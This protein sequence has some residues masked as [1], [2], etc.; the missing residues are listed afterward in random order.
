M[1]AQQ[2][3]ILLALGV[4]FWSGN[5][6]L[7]R[8]ISTQIEPIELAFFRWF[9]VLLFISPTLFFLNIKKLLKVFKNNFLIMS[10]LALL[11]I[12]L[13]NTIVY[14]AVQTTTA[15]NALL[16]NSTTPIIILIFAHYILKNHISTKQIFGILL[17]TLGVC[18]LILKGQVQ[19]I[20]LLEFHEGDLYILISSCIWALYSIL[21]KFKPK[22]LSNFE[23]F[24][25]FVIIGFI[26]LLPLY[27]Y[28]G[29]TIEQEILVLKANWYFII[30]ISL[31][32]SILSYYFWHLGIDN[33]GA[34]KTGQFTHLMPIFG[35]FLAFIF[36]GETLKYYHITGALLIAI[37]IYLSIICKK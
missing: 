11:G 24:T 18:F 37:G 19:N 3:Y 12:T 15:T 30:Y 14:T 6:V 17:S 5:F 34:E 1:K 33:I 8:Y 29:Y 22:E 35:S 21:V 25:S 28:Q 2:V 10:V 13:F 23:L 16:I 27:L 31:F 26:F 20:S 36:L 32:A 4:L 7:G 9:F